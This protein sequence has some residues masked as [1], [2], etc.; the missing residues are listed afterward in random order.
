[1]GGVRMVNKKPIGRPPMT[2]DEKR[3]VRTIKMSDQEWQELERRAKE[4]A[5]SIAEYIRIKALKGRI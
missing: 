1:M 5:V 2:S 4:Q 3:K